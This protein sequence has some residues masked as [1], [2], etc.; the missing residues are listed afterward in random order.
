MKNMMRL[1]LLAA[2][3]LPLNFTKAQESP[4]TTQDAVPQANRTPA[5]PANASPA[6]AE[7]I[8]L[9]E[10][11]VGDDVVLAYI[12]NAQSTFNLGA[13]DVLFLRDVGLSSAVITA[14]LSHDT[15][16]RNQAASNPNAAVPEPAQEP[17][18]P[19]S[20]ERRVGNECRY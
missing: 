8:R 7:V 13:D 15:T 11:G 6:A 20:E 19:R 17:P 3:A 18:P 1:G 4:P 14:M 5:V 12:Q 2:I 16:M 9:A 10:A